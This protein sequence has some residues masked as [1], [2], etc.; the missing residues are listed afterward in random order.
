MDSQSNYFE[1]TGT[2]EGFHRCRWFKVAT[3]GNFGKPVFCAAW[4][5][6]GGRH[7]WTGRTRGSLRQPPQSRQDGQRRA[8]LQ[9]QHARWQLAQ[10]A[11]C[12]LLV[13]PPQFPIT[14]Y[15]SLISFTLSFS[16]VKSKTNP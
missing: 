6:D 11:D 2:I 14:K 8:G 15:D 16:M 12:D 9:K 7:A 3:D 13:R 1:I 10:L 5:Q 4:S